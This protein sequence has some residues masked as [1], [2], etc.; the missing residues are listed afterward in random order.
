MVAPRTETYSGAITN[1]A[2][3]KR[4]RPKKIGVHSVLNAAWQ[5][6]NARATPLPSMLAARAPA[7][8]IRIYM[9]VQATGNTQSGGVHEGLFRVLYHSPGGNMAPVAPALVQARKNRRNKNKLMGVSAAFI[10]RL[11]L[12]NNCE[13]HVISVLPACLARIQCDLFV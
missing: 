10:L 2:P 5:A 1:S 7:M 3:F 4:R 12:W 11:F 6:Q 9:L 13:L 8:E